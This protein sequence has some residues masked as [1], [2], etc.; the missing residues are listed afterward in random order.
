MGSWWP[1]GSDAG[2]ASLRG[3]AVRWRPCRLLGERCGARYDFSTKSWE[4]PRLR[5]GERP[6]QERVG[7]RESEQEIFHVAVGL[8]ERRPETRV[9]ASVIGLLETT[10]REVEPL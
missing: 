7:L 2:E 1:R 8:L 3:R 10:I 4:F 9:G 5:S 6:V